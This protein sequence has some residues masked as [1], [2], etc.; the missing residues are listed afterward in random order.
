[1]NSG[2][3]SQR[4]AWSPIRSVLAV[5]GHEL[6]DAVRSRRAVVLLLMYFLG[7]LAA[8]LI[9][10]KVLHEVENR[11][12]SA[13]GVAQSDRAGGAT[14]TLWHN[15]HFREMLIHLTGDEKLALELLSMPP[16]GV[17]YG[18]LCFTF[19]PLLVVLM[20]SARISEEIWSGSVRFAL[21]RTSRL[22]WCM[23]K[24]VGQACLL[25]AAML[26]SGL[27]AWCVGWF[28]FAGFESVP[29]AAAIA[30]FAIKGW[31]YALAYLGLATAVSQMV[32]SPNLASALGFVGMV[33]MGIVSAV[34]GHFSG[35]G[36]RALLELVNILTPGGHKLDLW[37]LDPAHVLPAAV[38]MVVLSLAY[39]L[40]GHLSFARRDL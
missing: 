21:F 23:G 3:L 35:G 4:P 12:E 31:L 38:F 7:A 34:A 6:A 18:W 16:L 26:V 14:S 32:A 13:V 36:W 33:V 19:G 1:M 29:N 25:L 22:A 28:R 39:V 2:S 11:I 17:F 37:R 27:A 10:V 40:A 15:R 30:M 9:F 20:S 8:T 24:Y 5:A